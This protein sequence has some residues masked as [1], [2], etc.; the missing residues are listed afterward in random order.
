MN[1]SSLKD[2]FKIMYTVFTFLPDVDLI[3]VGNSCTFWR[4]ILRDCE[5]LSKQK[6]NCFGIESVKDLYER[7]CKRLW[8]DNHDVSRYPILRANTQVLK[9]VDEDDDDDDTQK[10][11][12]V[13]DLDVGGYRAMLLDNN[14]ENELF[15]IVYLE[16]AKLLR[17]NYLNHSPSSQPNSETIDLGRIEIKLNKKE[18]PKA[19]ENFRCLCTGEKGLSSSSIP[20]FYKGAT[21]HKAVQASI[22]QGGDIVYSG[23]TGWWHAQYGKEILSARN[24]TPVNE[25]EGFES[26]YGKNYIDDSNSLTHNAGSVSCV[27]GGKDQNGSQFTICISKCKDLDGKQIVFGELTK[28][29]DIAR[30]VE[31]DILQS[32]SNSKGEESSNID[33]RDVIF[34]KSCGQIGFTGKTFEMWTTEILSGVSKDVNQ[35]VVDSSGKEPVKS[36]T[37]Q[38]L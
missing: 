5:K 24:E 11:V 17:R 35:K 4:M 29:M 20:L 36:R 33:D 12:S 13:I 22:I 27:S 25:G 32:I 10:R 19:A 28:G 6:E 9:K 1:L 30:K 18:A 16:F 15:P 23:T 38:I 7:E 34:I 3:R 26:I 21:M 8:P 37:C 2:D 14:K 31:H